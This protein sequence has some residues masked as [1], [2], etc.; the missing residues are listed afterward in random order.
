MEAQLNQ[1]KE[2][3]RGAQKQ[4]LRE[5]LEIARAACERAA[6][7]MGMAEKYANGYEAAATKIGDEIQQLIDDMEEE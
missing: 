4:A 7:M 6:W 2:A 3:L 5:A 1:C